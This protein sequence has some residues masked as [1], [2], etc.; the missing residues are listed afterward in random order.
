MLLKSLLPTVL[1]C[2]AAVWLSRRQRQIG[3]RSTGHWLR[4]HQ[5]LSVA[6]RHRLVVLE[7]D[8]TIQLLALGEQGI[9]LLA[10]K[11]MEETQ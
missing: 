8:R 11:R 10:Q 4:V 1:L 3:R 9:Q 7:F 2:L 5:V 6:A